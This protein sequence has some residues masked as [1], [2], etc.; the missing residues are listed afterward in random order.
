VSGDPDFVSR[1]VPESNGLLPSDTGGISSNQRSARP[2][3]SGQSVALETTG[4]L[5]RPLAAL[6]RPYHGAIARWSSHRRAVDSRKRAAVRLDYYPNLDDLIE[7]LDA[8][9]KTTSYIYLR[10][11]L[12][13]IVIVG[14]VILSIVEGVTFTLQRVIGVTTAVVVGASIRILIDSARSP[15]HEASD[16]VISEA[17]EP[18][19]QPHKQG[20]FVGNTSQ[21][22]IYPSKSRRRSRRNESDFTSTES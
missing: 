3:F 12:I 10:V 16:H 9:S 20:V 18:A 2:E 6:V 15:T 22:L 11:V 4:L 17:P 5:R 19:G 1:H 7:E 21:P 14:C 13:P 8:Q